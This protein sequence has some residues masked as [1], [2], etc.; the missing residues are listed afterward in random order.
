MLMYIEMQVGN[1]SVIRATDCQSANEVSCAVT[2]VRV[3]VGAKWES[4]EKIATEI[5]HMLCGHIQPL[6]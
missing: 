2:S 6:K 3:I 1:C 5:F 4:G